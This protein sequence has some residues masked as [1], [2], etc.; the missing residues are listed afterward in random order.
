M[1]LNVWDR[2]VYDQILSLVLYFINFFL[3][4]NLYPDIGP[5]KQAIV[6]L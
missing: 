6:L 2:H 1:T 5:L 4:Y 3:K